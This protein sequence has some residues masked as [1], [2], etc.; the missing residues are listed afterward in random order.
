MPTMPSSG[1]VRVYQADVSSFPS[2]AEHEARTP[3]EARKI[4]K[5]PRVQEWAEFLKRFS[6]STYATF[7]YSDRWA[8]QFSI[9]TDRA[10]L[11]DFEYFLRAANYPC[12]KD[13]FAAVEWGNQGRQVPHLHVLL[14]ECYRDFL[15]K[16]W[17]HK[18]GWATVYPVTEGAHTYVCK[19]VLKDT[20]GDGYAFRLRDRTKE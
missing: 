7:T 5:D 11:R 12:D 4:R 1:E 20:T 6:L 10:A 19:Y 3:T 2:R 18:R 9:Y 17:Q 16:E 14:G 13:Y 8:Q 15:R